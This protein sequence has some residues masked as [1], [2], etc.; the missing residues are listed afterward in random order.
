MQPGLWKRL[1]LAEMIQL[2]Y[3]FIER[4][5]IMIAAISIHKGNEILPGRQIF[6]LF[7][8]FIFLFQQFFHRIALQ[9]DHFLIRGQTELRIDIDRLDMLTDDLLAERM[10]CAD[11]GPCQQYHLPLQTGS[12]SGVLHLLQFRLQGRLDALTHL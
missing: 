5:S 8:S 6:S 9:Q 7:R 2:Q 10:E 4:L 12:Q 1:A 11:I 3:G